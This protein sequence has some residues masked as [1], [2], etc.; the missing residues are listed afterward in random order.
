VYLDACVRSFGE[1]RAV[2]DDKQYALGHSDLEIERLKLQAS[3]IDP[4]TRRLIRECGIEAGM[5]VLDIGCGAGDVSFLLAEAVGP[6]GK[7]IGFD[8]E[9]KAVATARERAANLSHRNIEFVLADDAATLGRETFDATL[10]RYV[11]IHQSDP[12]AMIQR[13]ASTVR[14]GGIIAFHELVLDPV[15]NYCA[16][17]PVEIFSTMGSALRE[18]MRAMFLGPDA[19]TSMAAHFGQ[20]GF[21]KAHV[22]WELIVGGVDSLARLISLTYMVLHPHAVRLGFEPEG[23]GEIDTLADRIDAEVKAA[24]SQIVSRPQALGWARKAA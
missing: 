16:I 5:V 6:A 10:G 24:G 8:R 7:V 21:D 23:I 11:L 12:V 14:S 2:H 1:V 4:V 9:E 18:T 20:A 17:P 19:G 13:A 15:F 22:H 3:F